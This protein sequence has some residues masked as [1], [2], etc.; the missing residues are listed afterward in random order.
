MVKTTD[1]PLEPITEPALEITPQIKSYLN[2]TSKWTRFLAIVGFTS[3]LF[4]TLAAIYM[5]FVMAGRSTE[6]GS[7]QT[8]PILIAFLYL[9]VGAVIAIPLIKL[10]R[11]ADRLKG[12]LKS[13]DQNQLAASFQ[14]LTACHRIIGMVI[15][16]S[17]LLYA[18]FLVCS[19]IF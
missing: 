3:V 12:A 1:Q 5:G 16:G 14:Q 15:A 6:F 18:G 13:S 4:I 8:S 2:E 19:F 11:F 17:V 9:I 10:Y 7:V